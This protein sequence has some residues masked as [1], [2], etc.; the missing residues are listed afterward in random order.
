MVVIMSKCEVYGLIVT[1]IAYYFEAIVG[2]IAS[3][4]YNNPED[5]L[6]GPTCALI[7]SGLQGGMSEFAENNNL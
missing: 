4:G 3:L 5:F 7:F 6:L 1:N 2:D